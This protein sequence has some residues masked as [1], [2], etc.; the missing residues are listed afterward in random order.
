MGRGE[1]VDESALLEA[2]TTGRLGGAGLDVRAKE[3][4]ITGALET[5]PNVILTPHVAGISVQAQQRIGEILCDQIS[6]VLDGGQ[7]TCA[8][9]RHVVPV[10]ETVA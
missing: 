2:L 7:A 1:V 9:G 6:T 10:R 3:P 5:L 4:P 8:V